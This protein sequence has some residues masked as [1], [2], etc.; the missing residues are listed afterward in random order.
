MKHGRNTDLNDRYYEL[1]IK[2]SEGKAS[3]CAVC[4]TN[5]Q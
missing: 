4:D 3:L 1:Y 2:I 5:I